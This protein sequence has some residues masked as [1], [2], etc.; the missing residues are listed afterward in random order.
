MPKI[1]AAAENK[2]FSL[3]A[4]RVITYYLANSDAE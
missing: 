4:I 1:M 2:N 3:K